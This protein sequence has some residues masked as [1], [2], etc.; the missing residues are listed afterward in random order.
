M[1]CLL[2]FEFVFLNPSYARAQYS[3]RWYYRKTYS[4]F[5]DN[6]ESMD[7]NDILVFVRVAQAGSFSKAAQQLKMPV[8]TVSRRVA[9]LEEQLGVT[10]LVRTTR[11]LKITEVGKGYLQHG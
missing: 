1:V 8:S 9:E 6:T 7:L 11:S 2:K 3:S 5:W 4:H 10:L